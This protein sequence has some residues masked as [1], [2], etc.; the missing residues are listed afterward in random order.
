VS[1]VF[2]LNDQYTVDVLNGN[3][4]FRNRMAYLPDPVF[5]VTKD[6]SINIRKLYEIADNQ[7]II[8]IFGC[9]DDRKNVINSLSA[10][11]NLSQ[12]SQ[13]KV[14]LLIVGKVMDSYRDEI[15]AKI[16]GLND[17]RKFGL[18]VKDEFVDDVEMDALFQQSDLVLRM[19]INYFASS[20]IIGMSAK[21][22]RPSI[23]SNYGIVADITTK[24][25]LGTLVDPLNVSEIKQA[26]DN[27]IA[28]NEGVQ[29]EGDLYYKEHNCEA[30]ARAL[31]SL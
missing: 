26:I 2:V 6:K 9:I 29:S 27:F 3:K 31:L 23:V 8:L 7:F 19:N 25:K 11:E 17:S 14:T 10:L 24:Y 15:E 1:K 5:D 28:K 4:K 20:G 13:E 12:E 18:I 16:K 22:K 30:Y 21:Y